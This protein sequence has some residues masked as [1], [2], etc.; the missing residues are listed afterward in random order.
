MATRNME[1][2]AQ[3]AGECIPYNYQLTIEELDK[4]HE[5][6]HSGYDGEWHAITMLFNFGFAIGNRATRAGKVTKR[7]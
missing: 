1:Q 6:I 4:I 7:L 3:R 5:L 2:I